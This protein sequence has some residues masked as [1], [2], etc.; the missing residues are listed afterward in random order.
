MKT[1]TGLLLALGLTLACIPAAQGQSR[2]DDV[3]RIDVLDGGLTKRG[4]YQ[5]ALRLTLADGWKTYWRAPGDA[6]IPPQFFWSGSKNVGKTSISWPT[7]YV[8]EQNGLRSVGYKDQ[9][10]LP[11]EITRENSNRPVQLRGAVQLGVCREVCVPA[12]LVFDRRLAGAGTDRGTIAAAMADRPYSR[13]EAGVTSV[14]CRLDPIPDGLRVTA[15][16]AMP[17]SGGTEFAIVEPGI[18]EIWASEAKVAR[19]G[20]ILTVSSDL[21]HLQN[22]PYALDRSALRFTV[23]GRHHAV[24]IRGCSAN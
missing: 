14:S 3:V 7:P 2:L 21:V 13:D 20:G 12:E 1:F 9:L 19:A 22:K 6:G 11:V 23:L 24:D 8:F 4:T 5:A 10:V 17:H 15:R 16:I 18:A